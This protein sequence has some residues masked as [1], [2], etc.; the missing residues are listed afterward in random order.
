MRTIWT[1]ASRLMILGQATADANGDWTATLP[2]LLPLMKGCAPRAW[3]RPRRHPLLWRRH[4]LANCRTFS[5]LR[6]RASQIDGPTTGETGVDLKFNLTVL[7]VT[8]EK[9]Y[10]YTI[11]AT[12]L[13]PFTFADDSTTTRDLT[14]TKPGTKTITVTATNGINTVQATHEVEI[15]QKISSVN[16]GGPTSGTTGNELQFTIDVLPEQTGDAYTYKIEATDQTTINGTGDSSVGFKF[17]WDKPGTK[18]I[19]IM[20]SNGSDTAT[21][22]YTV[23]ITGGSSGDGVKIYLPSV[24]R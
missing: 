9:A 8:T 1:S 13:A 11:E 18:T 21:K 20:V 19:T 7:P 5:I 23:E 10:S 3:P 14:W 22:T 2:P 24:T 12:D 15:T 16:I 17:T 6:S 4:E